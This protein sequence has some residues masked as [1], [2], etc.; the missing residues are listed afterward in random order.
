MRK[1]NKKMKF[2]NQ[3]TI[4]I[5]TICQ[6]IVEEFKQEVNSLAKIKSRLQFISEM[7]TLLNHEL[8]LSRITMT[9]EELNE[10]FEFI[11]DRH[12]SIYNDLIYKGI[13]DA[14]KLRFTI[15]DRNILAYLHNK[16]K[17]QLD[18]E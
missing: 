9:V 3:T 11:K 7:V 4:R 10:Y 1:Q 18:A 5:S 8:M 13:S 6:V 14:N 16:F 15:N 2:L 12:F 17:N